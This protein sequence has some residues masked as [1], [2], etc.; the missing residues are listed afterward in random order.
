MN[1]IKEILKDKGLSVLKLSEKTG[2]TYSN[3]HSLVNRPNLESTPL[4]TLMKVSE[5]LDVDIEE[6][7]KDK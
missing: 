3:T 4:G 1:N 5:V 2:L 7:Y 6:L